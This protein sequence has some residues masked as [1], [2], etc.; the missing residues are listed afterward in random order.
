MS[1]GGADLLRLRPGAEHLHSL[2][3]RAIAEAM[4]ELAN[5]QT[6]MQVLDRYRRLTPQM[7]LAAGGDRF[8]PILSEV[9]K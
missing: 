3:A 2:G 5:A 7:L 8:P 1:H 9:P 6:A 4:L